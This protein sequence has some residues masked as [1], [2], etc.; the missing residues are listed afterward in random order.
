MTE[1]IN[2][3]IGGWQQQWMKDEGWSKVDSGLSGM[4]IIGILGL[5]IDPRLLEVSTITNEKNHPV[6]K[7]PKTQRQFVA[8]S[9]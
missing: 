4:A 8:G 9:L 1:T 7:N 5:D 3:G 6:S 2:T